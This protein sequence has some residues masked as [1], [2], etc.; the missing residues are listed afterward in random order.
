LRKELL[1]DPLALYQLALAYR[2]Q[3]VY[4]L[5]ILCAKRLIQLSPAESIGQAPRFLQ[6][7][8]YPLYF[9]DLVL[10]EA[11]ANDLDPLLLFALIYQ[12]S[13]FEGWATSSAGAQ[14]LTQVIPPTGEWIA[15]KMP[16]PDY[17]AEHLYRPYLN[18]K[19]GAWYLARQLQDFDNNLFV[20][21]AAYN[22]GPG[23]AKRWLKLADGDDDL[24]VESISKA[25]SKRYVKKVYE[26]YVRYR[27]LYGVVKRQT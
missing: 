23:N 14:G 13:L 26:H 24:F 21:L 20:A 18:V 5:S 25:E 15:L 3:G 1:S 6:R 19:F 16:W 2:E 10:A 9:D 8:V 22:G 12:E 11:Q 4:R 17:Q 7:L 27:E